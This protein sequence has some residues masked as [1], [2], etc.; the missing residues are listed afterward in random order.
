MKANANN[1]IKITAEMLGMT[2]EEFE[3]RGAWVIAKN[4]K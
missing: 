2:E 1:Q 3:E 4:S